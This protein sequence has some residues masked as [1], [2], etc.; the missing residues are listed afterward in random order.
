MQSPE[1]L[2]SPHDE[3]HADVGSGEPPKPNHTFNSTIRRLFSFYFTITYYMIHSSLFIKLLSL[4]CVKVDLNAPESEIEDKEWHFLTGPLATIASHLLSHISRILN[5]FCCVL[6]DVNPLSVS[7]K[8]PLVTLPNPSALSPIRRKLRNSEGPILDK[9]DKSDEFARKSKPHILNPSNI[10]FFA[11]QSLYVKFYELL[12]STNA[13]CKVYYLLFW[14]TVG[15]NCRFN[16][17]FSLISTRSPPNDY[18]VL[19]S[20]L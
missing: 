5:A 9:E 20:P 6:E 19:S 8:A 16:L 15:L 17:N 3:F 13:T 14:C 7:I 4:G 10:G 2:H 11:S 1:S 12:K 18:P